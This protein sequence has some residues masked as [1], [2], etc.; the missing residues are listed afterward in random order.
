MILPQYTNL[1][2]HFAPNTAALDPAGYEIWDPL[3]IRPDVWG[4]ITK[5]TLP[6]TF[7]IEVSVAA[8][9]E[10]AVKNTSDYKWYMSQQNEADSALRYLTLTQKATTATQSFSST[11]YISKASNGTAVYPGVTEADII[12]LFKYVTLYVQ[13]VSDGY[14]QFVTPMETILADR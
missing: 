6:V 12:G 9:A 2:Y 11:V 8:G 13:R 3:L 14:I 4:D 1:R 5:P 10:D 7:P